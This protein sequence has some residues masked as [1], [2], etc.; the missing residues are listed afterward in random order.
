MVERF[1]LVDHEERLFEPVLL[2]DKPLVEIRLG[3]ID[4][5]EVATIAQTMRLETPE[6]DGIQPLHAHDDRVF[7]GLE[8]VGHLDLLGWVGEEIGSFEE[9]EKWAGSEGG[10]LVCGRD[11]DAALLAAGDAVEQPLLLVEPAG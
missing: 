1:H 11:E 7:C 4:M 10:N 6:G 8:W 3:V 5:A 2:A 9:R